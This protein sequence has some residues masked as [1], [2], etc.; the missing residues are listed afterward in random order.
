MNG[1]PPLH[2][3]YP[4][5][6]G[7]WPGA[8]FG[9]SDANPHGLRLRFRHT[10]LGCITNCAITE[11]YCGFDGLVHGGVIATLLDEAAA[12]AVIARLGRLG[13]TRE[14][15]TRYLKPV[16]TAMELVVTGTI[17]SHDERGAIV[18]SRINAADGTLLA[19]AESTWAFPRLSRIAALA[20]VGETTLQQFIDSCRPE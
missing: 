20:G 15:T 11:T 16:P 14:M 5:I 8:C 10:E 3:D 18:R 6:P 17:T 19:E 13:V 4:E 12:W 1:A 9:C 7:R 2:S